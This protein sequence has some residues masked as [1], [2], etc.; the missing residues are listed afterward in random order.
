MRLKSLLDTTDRLL[1]FSRQARR[2]LLLQAHKPIPIP[3]YIPKF[4]TSSSSYLRRQDPDHER[5]EAAKLR[6]QYKQ[7]RKGAIRELRKDARFLAGIEQKKQKEKD[8]AYN[9]RMKRV[10]GSIEGERAE[11]KASERE[12]AREKK[13]SGRK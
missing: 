13:R 9:D 2:P 10:F 1:K 5:N 6:N 4:E 8:M 7:E 3:T 11:E 12:K